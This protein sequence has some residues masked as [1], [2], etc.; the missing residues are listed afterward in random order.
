MI[1]AFKNAF[2]SAKSQNL[3]VAL[4]ISHT[5]PVETD[6]PQDAVDLVK[7]FV[8]D[9]NIDIISSQLYTSGYETSPDYQ[10]TSSCKDI[11]CTWD[12]YK[13]F[14]GIFAPSIVEYGQYDAVKSYF[15]DN[16]GIDASGFI[17][18]KQYSS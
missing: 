3:V 9:E 12:L 15:K 8:A 16:Y 6:T 10:L 2:M 1:P 14:K 17:E 11:G 13:D 18:W 4:T 5:A 7:A